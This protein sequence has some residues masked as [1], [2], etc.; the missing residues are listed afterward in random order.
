[1]TLKS[2][3]IGDIVFLNSDVY[4]KTPLTVEQADLQNHT[5][6]V[7]YLTK[8]NKMNKTILHSNMVNKI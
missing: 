8:Y 3:Q 2:I 5:L 6:I 4:R 7:S 1:M